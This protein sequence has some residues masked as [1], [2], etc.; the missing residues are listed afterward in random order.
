M[1]KTVL[2]AFLR[3]LTRWRRGADSPIAVMKGSRDAWCRQLSMRE[4]WMRR[5]LK[6]GGSSCGSRNFCGG[7]SIRRRDK[8]KKNNG[9]RFI[10]RR[11]RNTSREKKMG[12]SGDG[13]AFYVW[14]LL[15]GLGE[16]DAFVDEIDDVLRGS[17]REEDFGDAGLLESGDVGFG[18]DAA[19]EDGDVG[20]AFF[21]EEFHELGADG[22]VRTGKDG[23][24]DDVNVFLDRGGGD[25]LRG[26]AQA[27]VNDFHA[28]VAQGAGDYFCA[29]VV[30]IQAR[31]GDQYSDF[32]YGHFSSSSP[33]S[34]CSQCS[35][36][37]FFSSCLGSNTKRLIP[38]FKIDTLKLINNPIRK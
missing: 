23:E 10:E 34:L 35:L 38:S 20:H 15:G 7:K 11:D 14:V 24:A 9:S 5:G 17:A 31:L 22:V 12:E 26:L 32:L 19:D 25:H 18:D 29:A 13:V 21:A 37:K 8:S 3:T 27:S 36:C 28:G 16:R 33:R 6:A 1:R 4:R 2:R 30:A